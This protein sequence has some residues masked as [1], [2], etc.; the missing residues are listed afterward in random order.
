MEKTEKTLDKGTRQFNPK[1]L[2]FACNWCSYAAA[3]LAGVSRLKVPSHFR[4]IRVMC[5]ARVRPEFVIYAFSRGV[6]GVFILGCHPGECHYSEGNFYT[7][8]RV[9][10]LKEMLR[11]V[12]IEPDRFQLRWVSASEGAKF[13]KT[14]KDMIESIR[15]LGPRTI[16][17]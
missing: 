14:M 5:S 6:D 11:F 15:D 3:D 2:V 10:L 4:V 16:G 7:R 12:G 17:T 13:A 1:I 9:L 8:R